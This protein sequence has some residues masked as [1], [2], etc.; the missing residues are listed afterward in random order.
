MNREYYYKD[1]NVLHL[2]L[3]IIISFLIAYSFFLFLP[4]SFFMWNNQINDQL[5]RLR[6]SIKGKEEITPYLIHIA[7]TDISIREL[8]LSLWDRAVYGK[9]INIL[10]LAGTDSIACDIIF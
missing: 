6:Y 7:L 8:G 9:I 5:F 1:K 4:D 10:Q 2:G 3:I